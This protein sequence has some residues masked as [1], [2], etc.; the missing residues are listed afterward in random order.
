[1]QQHTGSVDGADNN[2]FELFSIISL[3]EKG[4]WVNYSFQK[5]RR[6]NQRSSEPLH[7][8][9]STSRSSGTLL[10]YYLTE[11][12]GSPACSALLDLTWLQC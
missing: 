4:S 1:M 9:L 11:H 3:S 8:H 10:D 7:G 2:G 6:C 12:G 5:F